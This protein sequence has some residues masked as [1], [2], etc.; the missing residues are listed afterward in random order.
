M[1]GSNIVYV[2]DNGDDGIE[3]MDDGFIT[4]DNVTE[5]KFSFSAGQDI[6]ESLH[7][8]NTKTRQNVSVTKNGR[9][10]YS[11]L[12]CTYPNGKDTSSKVMFTDCII[13]YREGIGRDDSDYGRG[14]VSIGVPIA[15]VD[16]MMKDAKRYSSMHLAP[17]DKVQKKEGCYW[18]TCSLENLPET[19]TWIIFQDDSGDDQGRNVS[20][21]AILKDMK[22]SMVVDMMTTVSGSMTTNRM[23]ED[24]DLYNGKYTFTLKPTEMFIRD[25]SDK[26]G[27]VLDDTTRRRK[28]GASKSDRFRASGKLAEF[29][30][31]NL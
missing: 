16:K 5:M 8:K 6:T 23:D 22:S 9:I 1:S 25:K 27:P 18:F 7:K 12:T 10:A 4:H 13:Q 17:N 26:V 15:Y 14:Y 28:E 24:L 20:V 21:H 30:M 31:R 2:V 19:D 3:I 29:A 11:S